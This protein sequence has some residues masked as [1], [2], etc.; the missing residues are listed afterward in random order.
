MGLT[1]REL[2]PLVTAPTIS[3]ARLALEALAAPEAAQIAA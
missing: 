1:K 3:H 2:Q